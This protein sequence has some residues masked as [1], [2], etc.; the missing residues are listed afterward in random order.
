MLLPATLDEADQAAYLATVDGILLPGG[1]DVDP[2]FQNEDPHPRLDLVNPL[3]D[4]FEIAM[5]K[6][7]AAMARPVLGICR[8]IQVL[9]IALGGRIHQDL[10][11]IQHIQHSQ[12]AP[13]WAPSHKVELHQNSRVAAWLD[14]GSVY[15]NSF[16]HQ[17]VRDLPDG[18]IISGWTSDGVVEAIEHEDAC[19]VGVQWHP[20][21]MSHCDASAER[22]F[23]KFVQELKKG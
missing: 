20:E 5:V 23:K 11:G 2:R 7:A 18:F 9:A 13:R 3:R 16:H 19:L 15:T 22:L 1:E 12:K 6:K 10:Q 14:M 17:A 21:E 4:A 8:G